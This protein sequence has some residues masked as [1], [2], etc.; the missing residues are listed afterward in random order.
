MVIDAQR[1][2]LRLQELESELAKGQ[3]Q[4]NALAQR[5][6]ELEST[7]LRLAGAIQ[8]LDEL[9][10]AETQDTTAAAEPFS[11]LTAAGQA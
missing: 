6:S 1:I 5:R 2:R 8:V 7:L 11:G 4:M 9:L 10:T 3:Q